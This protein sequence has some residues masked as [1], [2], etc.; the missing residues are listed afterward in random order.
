M[1]RQRGYIATHNTQRHPKLLKAQPSVARCK[2]HDQLYNPDYRRDSQLPRER[3]GP[4][5]AAVI[6]PCL[7]K[8]L[9]IKL[10]A[11]KDHNP[12]MFVAFTLLRAGSGANIIPAIL[13][14]K[15][16]RPLL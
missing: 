4:A 16:T 5:A 15:L 6:R 9:K 13:P 12:I 10:H 3:Q 2:K 1:R 11:R 14:L 7:R 8:R